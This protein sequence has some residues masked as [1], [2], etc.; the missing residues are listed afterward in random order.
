M[1]RAV[2]CNIALHINAAVIWIQKHEYYVLL[3]ESF[4]SVV[5][6]KGSEQGGFHH[7]TRV[8]RVK[9]ILITLCG[10]NVPQ[11]PILSTTLYPAVK[12]RS[13]NINEFPYYKSHNIEKC[14]DSV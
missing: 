9:S 2:K 13:W 4:H 3:V 12:S 1:P 8:W 10:P 5:S 6:A 7:D 14:L 11:R